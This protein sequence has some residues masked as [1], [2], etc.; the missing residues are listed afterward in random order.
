MIFTSPIDAGVPASGIAGCRGLLWPGN[1]TGDSSLDE[2]RYDSRLP[3]YAVLTLVR[4]MNEVANPSMVRD[5]GP[6]R[7]I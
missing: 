4:A 2:L 5:F 3:L 1:R 6:A 7:Q